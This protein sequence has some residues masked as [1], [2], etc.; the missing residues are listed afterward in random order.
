M[1]E[2]DRILELVKKGII[3]TEE[4]IS[5][6][7][8]LD[9]EKEV[10]TT[11]EAPAENSVAHMIPELN[12]ESETQTEAMEEEI[13]EVEKAIDEESAFE[14]QFKT[15]MDQAKETIKEAGKQVK[16][17][18]TNI[19]QVLTDVFG[20][21][22]TTLKENIDWKEVN[23]KV[24]KMASTSFTHHFEYPANQATIIDIQNTN[25]GVTLKKGTADKVV[26]QADVKIY[27]GL[28]TETPLDEFNERSEFNV[29][30]EKIEVSIPSKFIRANLVVELPERLY[31]H[32]S[33]KT[34]NGKVEVDGIEAGDIY[35]N[36]TNGEVDMHP[37]KASMVEVKGVNGKVTVRDAQIIDTLVNT[38][39]GEVIVTADSNAVTVSLVNGNMR[40]TLTNDTLTKLN[41]SNVNGNI[42]TAFPKGVGLEGSV[43][44]T[45]GK[46]NQRLEQI[47]VLNGSQKALELR[48]TGEKVVN[49]E[50]RTTT[51]TVFLKDAE[52]K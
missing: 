32:I 23:V 24:P 39:N 18:A 46:I 5:L 22:R 8:Q 52:S 44:T 26:I 33:I 42:K 38:V 47:D 28:S 50:I 17:Y 25:G 31:D 43:S 19:G 7:E 48:R 20:T 41:L 37:V 11:K 13:P 16:P 34:L 27:G 51:G 4:G 10:A 45:F 15:A 49:F 36:S 29:T 3:S 6:L 21:V 12:P 35:T 1:S 2:K 14:D 30:D 40:L 9:G